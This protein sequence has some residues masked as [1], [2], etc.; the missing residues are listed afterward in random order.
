M[1][2]YTARDNF[3]PNIKKKRKK[4]S[5]FPAL[6]VRILRIASDQGDLPF[7]ENKNKKKEREKGKKSGYSPFHIEN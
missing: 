1:K 6:L 2:V 5:K 7:S 3:N 4:N